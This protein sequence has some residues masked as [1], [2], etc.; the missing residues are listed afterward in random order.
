MVSGF[1]FPLS[2]PI[3]HS[4]RIQESRDNILS[5]NHGLPKHKNLWALWIIAVLLMCIGLLH[6]G[7]NL[8]I[9]YLLMTLGHH[10]LPPSPEKER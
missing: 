5:G 2:Q 10:G 3:E 9:S 7:L 1:D 8:P 4:N 6:R